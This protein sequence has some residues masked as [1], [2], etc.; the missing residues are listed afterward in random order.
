MNSILQ[1]DSSKCFKCK[2]TIKTEEHHIFGGNPNRAKSEKYGLKVYLCHDCH[3]RDKKHKSIHFD[4]DEMLKLHQ[5]GQKAFMQ[6]Y[7]KTKDE[8][9]K[10]FG[11]NYL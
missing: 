1:N 8:F 7:N 2:R 5:I 3:N 10:E 6:Y 9:R 4:K 11:K